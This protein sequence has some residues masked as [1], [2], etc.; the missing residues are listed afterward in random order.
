MQSNCS[1]YKYLIAAITTILAVSAITPLFAG[2]DLDVVYISRTPRYYKYDVSYINGL[3]PRDWANGKPYLTAQEAAKQRWPSPGETVVFTAVVKNPGDAPTGDFTYKWY[4]DGELIQTSTAPSIAPGGRSEFTYTWQ[5]DSEWNDHT[6]KFEVDPDNIIAENVETNNS[7]EDRTNALSFRFHVWQSVYDWFLTEAPK[8]NPQI[9]SFEDWAQMQLALINQ[10]FKE[11]VFPLAPNGILERVRLDE[12]V[13]EPEDTPDPDPW[14]CHAPPDFEWDCR[15]GF[16]PAEY[17]RIFIENPMFI[18]GR[19]DWGH[20]E[21]GH[22]M[23]LIDLYRFDLGIDQ[24]HI[25]PLGHNST[26][27]FCMMTGN[28]PR[29]SDHTA[30]AINSKL[31]KRCGYFG[32]Y[33]YDVPR[34]CRVRLLDAYH[35]PIPNATIRFYQ[36]H[37]HEFNPPADFIGIT[38]EAG[39]FTLPNR[40]CYG[41]TT[42]GTGH[43]LHDNPWGLIYVVGFNG[44]FLCEITVDGQTDYQFMEI[45]PFNVAYRAGHT[46]SY[47]YDLQTT[48]LPGGKVTTNNLYAIKMIS[49]TEGYAVGA[50]GIILM[51]DGSTWAPMSSPTNRTLRAIDAKEGLVCAV[52]DHGAVLIKSGSSWIAKNFGPDVYFRACAVASANTIYIGGLSGAFY[53]STDGGNNWTKLNVTNKNIYSLSFLNN[54]K[55]IMGIDDCIYYTGKAGMTWSRASGDFVAAPITGCCMVT[56]SEA[57]ACNNTGDIL[58]STD[59]GMTWTMVLDCGPVED[60][61]AIDIK[62]G[63]NGWCVGGFHEYNYN[64]VLHRLQNSKVW[65]DPLTV[66]GQSDEIYGISCLSGND[67]W[68]VGESG[69]IIHLVESNAATYLPASISETKNKSNGTAVTMSGS[70]VTASFPGS[71]YVESTDRTCGLKVLTDQYVAPGSLVSVVGVLDTVGLERVIRYG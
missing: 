28:E 50:D 58:K 68:A 12:V 1:V 21:W 6:I 31:H 54:T 48:I 22:Q 14:A 55:G 62:S 16:T 2:P 29:Y 15:W 5:W 65:V 51:W 56:S 43:T 39:Y 23:G 61:K 19:Y 25:V 30:Y 4:F 8:I 38:D 45:L 53:R 69:L 34:T 7:R 13:V 10:Y 47:T 70:A 44:T 3:D 24:N 59:G 27:N 63:G 60:W 17:P 32:E 20:H 11:A 67:A 49:Q 37:C 36:N 57:W 40:T 42:T 64:A 33:L 9:A 46:Q 35:K 26:R 41:E 71:I 18:T 52:G 66:Y